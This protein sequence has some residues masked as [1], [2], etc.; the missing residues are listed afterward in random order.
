M[1]TN[2]LQN[3]FRLYKKLSGM[4]GTADT[5]AAEFHSTYKLDCVIIPTNKP[6]VRVDHEDLVYKT[7]KEKFTAVINEILEKHE[8][9]QPMLV[10]T[11][12]VEKSSAIARIL[13]KKGVKH[14]VLN[15][16]HH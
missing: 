9:G 16:K 10:G 11:T 2:T 4:T 12:S 7:E 14:N 6:V 8:L 1:A 3:L 13:S 5:E 15:A